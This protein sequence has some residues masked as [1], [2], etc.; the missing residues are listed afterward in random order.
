MPAPK[1]LWKTAPLIIDTIV[2]MYCILEF[3]TRMTPRDYLF[4]DG[5]LPLV[6]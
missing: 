6:R 2:Y 5:E 3:E 4:N 1:I